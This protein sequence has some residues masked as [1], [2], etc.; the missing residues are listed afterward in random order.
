MV[1][2]QVTTKI[3][4]PTDP[5]TSRDHPPTSLPFFPI[6]LPFSLHFPHLPLFFIPLI[7]SLNSAHLNT[8]LV[9]YATAAVSSHPPLSRVSRINVAEPLSSKWHVFFLFLVYSACFGSSITPPVRAAICK[10]TG[11]AT[12][13]NEV[14]G[15]SR[16]IG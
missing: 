1:K 15:S 5:P 16:G 3:Q 8:V 10:Q 6:F 2:N 4:T 9:P 11:D 12:C 7:I 14:W 13:S